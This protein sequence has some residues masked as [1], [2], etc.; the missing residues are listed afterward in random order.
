MKRLGKILASLSLVLVVALGVFTFVG[1]GNK[2]NSTKVS[3]AEAL[4]QAISKGGAVKLTE[5]ISVSDK[6]YL[7]DKD[8]TIDLN[9]HF[10]TSEIKGTSAKDL[11]NVV[12]G[13]LTINATDGGSMTLKGKAGQNANGYLFYVGSQKSENKAAQKGELVINGGNFKVEND[14]SVVQVTYGKATI[15]GGKFELANASSS[16]YLLNRLNKTDASYKNATKYPTTAQFDYDKDVVIIVNGGSFKG[17]NP[18][19]N[20]VADDGGENGYL[21]K[22]KVAKQGTDANAGWY[23][24]EN[25]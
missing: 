1:C 22:D 7:I 20:G 12:G 9:N 2:D 19:A 21:G 18:G 24:V 25:A 10:L 11:F 23:I 6:T 17:F 14:D 4:E 3:D 8:V 13:T 15:N 5:D 16:K